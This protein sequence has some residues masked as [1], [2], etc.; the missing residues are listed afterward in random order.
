MNA[1]LVGRDP[2]ASGRIAGGQASW[3]VALVGLL[4]FAVRIAHAFF[5]SH[6]PFFEGPIIDAHVYWRLAERIAS[7]GD[8]GAAFYQPPLYP[9]FLALLFGAQL[10][11]AWAV[12]IVQAALGALSAVLMLWIGRR[13]AGAPERARG[14]GLCAGL[15]T[16]LYGPFVLFDLEFM[17]PVVV[18]LL[19]AAALLLALRPWR[20]SLADGALG[21]ALGLAIVGFPL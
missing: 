16:A 15:V 4:A 12:A 7:G 9:A 17:P 21:L 19:L 3:E 14:V 20:S 6:T 8:F 5:V 18:D 1:P 11:S 2:H 10:S 13:L